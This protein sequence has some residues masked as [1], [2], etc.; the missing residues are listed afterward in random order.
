MQPRWE[1]S[2]TEAVTIVVNAATAE[3]HYFYDLG[4]SA[5]CEPERA[6]E[7]VDQVRDCAG[8]H[9]PHVE[10]VID[11]DDTPA[12]RVLEHCHAAGVRAWRYGESP[13]AAP[14]PRRNLPR[15]GALGR[16]EPP[17]PPTTASTGEQREHAQPP[18]SLRRRS[19]RGSA[20]AQL[21]ERV[22]LFSVGIVAVVLLVVG[23][24]WWSTRQSLDPAPVSA[25]AE[26]SSA[27]APS[28]V[29][30][31][32]GEEASTSADAPQES[33]VELGPV[34]VR[35][36]GGF[37]IVDRGDGSFQLSGA[38][39]D[40]RIIISFDEVYSVDPAAVIAEVEAMVAV[41]ET[42]RTEPAVFARH[43]QPVHTSYV[44]EP[45][46]G[47]VVRW[48]SWVE[49]GSLVSVGCHSRGE[50][51]HAHTASCRMAVDSLERRETGTGEGE[52]IF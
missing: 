46:D 26:P 34:R 43:G 5:L 37:Q 23:V 41:D 39:P 30:E 29:G 6:R 10:V 21:W 35:T 33:V 25:R 17:H 3:S 14:T 2:I 45:G 22:N 16:T 49:H 15:P 31:N 47:S 44:E 18:R 36:P 7:L 1:I 4:S 19:L 42:L 40:L 32:D 24:S 28:P 48:I 27:D 13:P 12:E 20:A 11:A 8:S 50:P 52:K 51:S 38:D 9:W